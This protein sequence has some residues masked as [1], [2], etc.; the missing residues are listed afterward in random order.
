MFSFGQWVLHILRMGVRRVTVPMEAWISVSALE[1]VGRTEQGA[2]C[3]VASAIALLSQTLIFL[4][5][6]YPPLVIAKCSYL[7]TS[8][9][10]QWKIYEL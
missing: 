8:K 3:I 9:L 10:K 1:N 5:A 7:Y 6:E 4:A 2:A